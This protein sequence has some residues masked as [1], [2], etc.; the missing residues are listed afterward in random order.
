M[1]FFSAATSTEANG[2]SHWSWPARA[3]LVLALIVTACGGGSQAP[4]GN[5]LR[6]G[7]AGSPDTANPGTAVLSEAYTIFGLV[8]DTMYTVELDGTFRPGLAERWTASEDG[9]IL[10]YV[11]H[12]GVTFHDG[13]PL[14]A[15]DVAFS[16]NLYKRH[17]DFPFLNSYTRHFESVEAADDR[18]V[19]IRLTAALPNIESQLAFL[20]VL[21]KHIWAPH[22]EGAAAAEFEN[23]A[24]VGSGPFRMLEYRPNEFIR[25]GANK[26]HFLRRP[27]IDGVIF[28]TFANQDALVQALRTG[29]VDMITEIPPTA[30]AGLGRTL[31]IRLAT[32]I[33]LSPEVNDILLNQIAS[34]NCPSGSACAGHPAL[35]DRNLR[36]A[37]AHGTDKQ[38]IIDVVLLGHGAP[39]LTLIPDGLQPWFNTHLQDYPF[40]PAKANHILDRAGYA[41]TNGDG[42]REMPGSGRP[43]V[44][45][46]YRP[47]DSTVA[48]GMSDLL[49]EMWA[50]IGVRTEA[51]SMDPDALT[52]ACCPAFDYDIILWGWGSDPDPNLLLGAMSTDQIPTGGNETG[53]SN[54]EYDGLYKRQAIERDVEKRREL[55]WKMQE[56][57]HRDVVY[58]V[59]FY[60]RAVQAYRTDRFAGWIADAPR[61]ALEERASLIAIE[62]ASRGNP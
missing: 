2:M 11:I 57:V 60:A 45:R 48:P 53:Y 62:P 36:L 61:V 7:W 25:L 31:G 20:Y 27:K 6:I 58:I 1:K 44:F 56:I 39:G 37:L 29:Q 23:A 3:V 42:V 13:R 15:R 43:L 4:A 18:T 35:R 38:K 30:V 52:A 26:E 8:Y 59:P 22:A 10:T 46:L 51:R 5:S 41:D 49:S 9:K 16:Y 50:Q 33:P 55:V 19:V 54:P 28:Q 14:T 32:G 21:P 34:E 17:G 47:S 40:D 12:S 24:M